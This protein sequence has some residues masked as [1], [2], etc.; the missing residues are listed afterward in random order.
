MTPG[1]CPDIYLHLAGGGTGE[2]SSCHTQTG[3]AF[4]YEMER[5]ENVG[6]IQFA[7]RKSLEA[8]CCSLVPRVLPDCFI[9][10]QLLSSAPP[11][12]SI[13]TSDRFTKKLDP[14]LNIEVQAAL[15]SG[16]SGQAGDVS[17]FCFPLCL[18]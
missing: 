13:P 9:S 12:N 4:F 1:R 3:K 8:D 14:T 5:I 17:C 15:R 11:I 2:V 18:P 16:K 7:V 6:E 10:L